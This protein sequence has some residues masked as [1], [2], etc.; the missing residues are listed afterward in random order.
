VK[1]SRN[2]A[3]NV[4]YRAVR[5]AARTAVAAALVAVTA[6]AAL[7]DQLDDIK[8]AGKIRIAVA[9]GSPLYSFAD[10]N[11]Q[12]AGSD[13]ETA[14]LLAKDLGVEMEMVSI[15]N[16]ARIPTLQANKADIDVADLSITEE[17]KKVIDFSKPYAVITIIL[18]APKSTAI[19]DYADLNGKRIGL[20]RATVNDTM[21]TQ[22]AKG[23]EIVRYED[24]ATLITSVVTGQVEV[25]SSTPANLGEIVKR[26]PQLNME[27][28]FDQKDFD[29]GI[30]LQKGQPRLKEWVDAWVVTNM[31]NGKLNAIYK[32]FHGRDLPAAVTSQQ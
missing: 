11:M 26:A 27:K 10:A 24:D 5:S 16:A 20:T 2:L 3:R 15:T 14:Q 9:M 7:A 17:R 30:A 29:L 18:A 22:L 23:A 13:V 31:K 6:Q 1:A 12:P 4:S 28:K 19:K 21:T 8:K 32:K 25:W